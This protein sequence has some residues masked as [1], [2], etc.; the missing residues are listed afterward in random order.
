MTFS[1][2]V[3]GS[4]K[5]ICYITLCKENIFKSD[6]KFELTFDEFECVKEFDGYY[7]I[8]FIK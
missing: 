4:N 6:R 8:E 3:A 5:P 2:H 1:S 7:Y